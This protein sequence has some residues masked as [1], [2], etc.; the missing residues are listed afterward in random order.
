MVGMKQRAALRQDLPAEERENILKPYLFPPPSISPSPSPARQP[1]SQR[2]RK[3]KPLHKQSLQEL[4]LQQVHYL[5]FTL[6]HFVF[7]IYVHIRQVYNG[8]IS[9]LYTLLKHHHRTPQLIQND[10]RKL[11][12]MPQHLSV[13][14]SL[15]N[16]GRNG[17][18]RE[19]VNDL[20]EI[21]AWCAA[22]GIGLLSVYEKT[23]VLKHMIPQTHEAVSATFESYWGK[24]KPTLSLRAPQMEAYSPPPSPPSAPTNGDG[25]ST[26]PGHLTILLLSAEDGRGTL[27]DL[28]KT[29]AEMAQQ[30]KLRS[31]DINDQLI[32]AEISEGVMGEPE[33]LVLFGPRVE[34]QGYPPWQMRLTEIFHVQDHQGVSYEV[35]LRA[36]HKFAKAEMRFG[37]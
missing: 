10:V 19:L 8:V 18:L 37:R 14:L 30:Q 34:L 31:S 9:R 25:G 16:D 7:S 6:A 21:A 35:F 29:L 13:V 15:N 20:G 28:T 12:R 24:R 2:I 4:V 1:T 23:G 5:I 17:G 11:N 22:S 27:V 32:D 33:L 26:A 3:A 36:L